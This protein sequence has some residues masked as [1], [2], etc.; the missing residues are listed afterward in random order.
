[1][2]NPNPGV[3]PTKK[4]YVHDDGRNYAAPRS[5]DNGVGPAKPGFRLATDAEA[6]R[7]LAGKPHA[8][9]APAKP[10]K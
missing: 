8:E 6:A 1:M 3:K 7:I 10:G 5:G 4:F 2:S 9:P